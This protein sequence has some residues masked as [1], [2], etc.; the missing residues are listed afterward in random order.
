[1]IAASLPYRRPVCNPLLQCVLGKLVLLGL[2]G[3]DDFNPIPVWIGNEIDSHLL[4]FVADAPH[5]LVPCVG[6]IIVLR[7]HCQ[8]EF[9]L[10]QIIGLWMVPQPC[11]LQAEICLSVTKKHNDKAPVLRRFL[12]TSRS[13][14]AS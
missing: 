1:M 5:G 2:P 12:C 4:V 14:S 10:P 7:L 9:T 3:W 11:Q 6:G 13:P 8:M